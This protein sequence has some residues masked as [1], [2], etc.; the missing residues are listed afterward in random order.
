MDAKRKYTRL[1]GCIKKNLDKDTILLD[2]IKERNRHQE[3]Y[4]ELW[5]KVNLDEIIAKFDPNSVPVINENGKIIFRTPGNNIQVVAEATIGSVRIQDLS[6]VEGRGY[7]DL[8]GNRMNNITENGK[9]RGLSKKE[10]EQKTHPDKKNFMK[11]KAYDTPPI[12]ISKF[13][14]PMSLSKY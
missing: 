14:T 3:K 12:P 8:E 10:Y 4:K 6:I 5:Q 9:T 11:G 2:K 13:F 1:V 7:L